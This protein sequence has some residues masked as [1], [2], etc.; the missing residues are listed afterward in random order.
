MKMN[1]LLAQKKSSSSLR[2]KQLEVGSVTR[3]STTP[4]GQKPREVKSTPY[5]SVQ[6]E[7]LLEAKGSFIGKSELGTTDTGKSLC[8]TLLKT[9]QTVPDDSLFHDDL[10]EE[11]CKVV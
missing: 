1:H 2:R 4:S 9:Q 5:R 7:I 3:S 10:F 6:Y 11:T 8:L